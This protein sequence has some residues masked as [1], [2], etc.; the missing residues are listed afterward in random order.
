M[1]NQSE[2]SVD[3]GDPARLPDEQAHEAYSPVPQ[4]GVSGEPRLL[5]AYLTLDSFIISFINII[6]NVRDSFN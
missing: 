2:S 5:N 6:Q 4:V 1:E 3:G